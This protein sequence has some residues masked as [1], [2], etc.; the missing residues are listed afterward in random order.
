M[1]SNRKDGKKEMELYLRRNGRFQ[2]RTK[3]EEKQI[4]E[5]GRDESGLTGV[6][7]RDYP[8]KRNRQAI[9]I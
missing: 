8:G 3:T 5:M 4:G 1:I 7:L 6:K 9:K 2:L